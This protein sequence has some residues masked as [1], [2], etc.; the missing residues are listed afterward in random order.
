MI[1]A[2]PMEMANPISTPRNMVDRK[3]HIHTH[4]SSLRTCRHAWNVISITLVGSDVPHTGSFEGQQHC[5]LS[6]EGKVPLAAVV[7]MWK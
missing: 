7:S 2:R 5:C 1:S 6:D 3:E 4:Q